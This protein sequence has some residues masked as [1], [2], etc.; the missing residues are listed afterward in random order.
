MFK[1]SSIKVLEL[2]W[3]HNAQRIIFILSDNSDSCLDVADFFF[4]KKTPLCCELSHNYGK[5]KSLCSL[6]AANIEFNPELM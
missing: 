3:P 5:P 4:L 6:G 1:K 2:G